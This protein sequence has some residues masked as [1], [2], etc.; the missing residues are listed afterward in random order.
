MT[1]C[2]RSSD[3]YLAIIL[4]ALTFKFMWPVNIIG[5]CYVINRVLRKKNRGQFYTGFF[6]SEFLMTIFLIGYNLWFKS[7]WYFIPANY[8][9]YALGRGFIHQIGVKTQTIF[10]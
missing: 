10:R 1:K 6:T 7:P 3:F 9:I 4:I 8:G 2:Y 5:S